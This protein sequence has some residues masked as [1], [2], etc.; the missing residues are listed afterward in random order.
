MGYW[1]HVDDL[2]TGGGG[3]SGPDWG[4]CLGCFGFLVVVFF[5]WGL[6]ESYGLD[7]VLVFLV[8]R[9]LL[10]GSAA[11]VFG[12]FYILKE[13]RFE[14]PVIIAGGVGFAA[15]TFLGLYAGMGFLPSIVLAPIGAVAAMFLFCYFF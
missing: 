7:N 15:V 5:L 11:S 4:G 3:S 13:T 6:N 9:A 2:P 12:I 14:R 10:L 1:I 8:S